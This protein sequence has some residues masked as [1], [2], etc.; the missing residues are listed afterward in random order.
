[1]A[2][3][4]TSEETVILINNGASS[5]R[6]EV[7][8][9]EGNF[10]QNPRRKRTHRVEM[11]IGPYEDLRVRTALVRSPSWDKHGSPS[12][13]GSHDVYKIMRSLEAS[14]QESMYAM[15]LNSKNQ[16]HGIH[17]LAKGG[18]RSIAIEPA[19]LFQAA[20]VAN[21]TGVILVHNHPSGGAEPS[22]EDI[23]LT[24]T[25]VEAGDILGIRLLDSIVIGED[26]YVS[27]ADRGFM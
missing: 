14:P 22:Q 13:H 2:D 4:E 11:P 7:L 27:L 19:T 3:Y 16:V 24:R 25:A 12:I 18:A 1:M 15:L 10:V 8:V 21:A 6:P 20:I 26:E 5:R 17:E 23:H 9:I